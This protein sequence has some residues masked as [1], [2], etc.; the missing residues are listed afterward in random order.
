MPGHQIRFI[1]KMNFERSKPRD[2]QKPEANK[3]D[4][5]YP[6]AEGD[7]NSITA[8]L[9]DENLWSQF[10]SQTNEMIVTKTGRKMFPVV[11]VKLARLEPVTFYS[12]ILEFKQI[13]LSKWK[14]TNG[15]WITGN[16]NNTSSFYLVNCTY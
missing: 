16:F 3:I 9:E 15:R 4:S 2:E 10:E 13:D 7:G 5:P 8:S 12:I 6:Y 11:R 1:F 14:F